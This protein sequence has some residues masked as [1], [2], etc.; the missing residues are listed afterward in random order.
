VSE[1]VPALDDADIPDAPPVDHLF[2][3]MGVLLRPHRRLIWVAT[4]AM[5]LQTAASLGGPAAVKYG[6]DRGIR[7]HDLAALNRAAAVFLVCVVAAYAFGRLTI[8]LVARIG[9]TF[10]RDLRK[11]I[12]DHLMSLSLDFFERNRTGVLVSR[13]TADIDAM[14]DLVGQGLTVFI[15]SALLF[16]GTV[17]VMLGMSWQLSIAVLIVVPILASGTGWFRRASDRA[18]LTLRDR[19]GITL[20]VMQEGLT[21]VRVSQAFAQEPALSDRFA[22]VNDEQMRAHL[23]TQRL[24][25]A[26]F[27]L[28]DLAKGV[29]I[30]V[31]LGVG[32]LL[33]SPGRQ[34]VTVGTVAAFVLYLQN[35][36]DPI[37]QLSQLFNTLQSAAAALK[38]LF[39]LLDTT[40]SVD[41]R[42]GAIDLPAG[43]SLEV[44]G[45]SFRYGGGPLV[46]DDV[47]IVVHPGERLAL[48]GPTGAGK[49]TLA[50]LMTRF[51]DPTAGAVRYGGVDLRDATLA[52]LRER[53]LVVPQE[54]YLFAGTVR[55]NVLLGRAGVGDDEIL[56]SL[57][58]LGI[59]PYLRSLPAGLDTPVLQGGANFSAGQRQLVSL[60]RCALVDPSVLVLDEATSSLDLGT[61]LVVEQAFERLMVGRTVIVIAHR[62]STAARADRVAVVDGG[63]IIECGPHGELVEAGGHYARLFGA[64]EGTGAA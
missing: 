33:S 51:Y 8:R 54:G 62:L 35:V 22:D 24:A 49:S 52:S 42:A 14:Q 46:L 18:Y 37:Q 45:V 48:V 30:A 43:G 4:V 10:L 11:Q 29:A 53:I 27:P 56:E 61:E 1:P 63:R 38:K 47:S 34:V 32:G 58:G 23:R 50:K 36:F 16:V 20:T 12:F 57:D 28:V 9:E 59:G 15:T 26:Y 13:M 7:H 31:T 2:R 60:A 17:V 44:E 19:I 25:A 64:W 39:G 41:E 55:D 5:V 21:G 3:R 40:A 6:I